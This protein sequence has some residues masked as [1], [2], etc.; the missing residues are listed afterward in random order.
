MATL[1]GAGQAWG[2]SDENRAT[3]RAAATQGVAA[4]DAGNWAEAIEMFTRA[5]ALVH[6]PPH[7]LH[8][9]RAEVKRGRLVAAQ[10]AY[11]K[12]TREELGSTAPKAFVEA[13]ASANEELAALTPRIPTLKITVSGGTAKVTMDKAPVADAAIGIAIPVD[14][15]RHELVA[16]GNGLQS[17]PV[18]VDLAEGKQETVKLVLERAGEPAAASGAPIAADTTARRS[19]VPAYI[20]WGIGGAGLVVGTAMLLVNR[21]KR[22]DADALCPN[23]NC[24]QSQKAAIQDLDSSADSAATLSWVGYGVGIAGLGAGTVLFLMNRGGSSEKAAAGVRPWF[25][26][27]GAGATGWF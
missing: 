26:A 12:V 7:L 2:Q 18:V 15:G 19:N 20:A 21:G 16:Q 13:Q 10:E 22:D 24:P 4:E 6:A 17:A 9:A 25:S 3:A 8:I 1:L 5:E 27:T 14:P 11:L 23:G